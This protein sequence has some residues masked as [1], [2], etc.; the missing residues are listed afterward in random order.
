MNYQVF[1]DE[2]GRGRE[3]NDREQRV[4]GSPARSYAVGITSLLLTILCA[5]SLIQRQSPPDVQPINAPL[6]EFASGR[7][8]QHLKV[9][10][11]KPH[12]VGS[13][14]HSEVRDYIFR[15]LSRLGLNPEV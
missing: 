13:A 2:I 6:T 5:F 15:E 3:S 7:A 1:A 9:I 4:T 8:M 10:A 14:E 11:R 12:P